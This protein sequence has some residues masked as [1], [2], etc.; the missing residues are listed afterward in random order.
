MKRRSSLAACAI[1]L[2]LSGMSAGC[3]TNNLL[4]WT[5]GEKSV[6]HRPPENDAPYVIPGATVLAFPFVIVWDIVT[7]P[8]QI[9]WGIHPYGG[10]M[11]PDET[12][13]GPDQ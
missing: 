2:A 4:R 7:F 11:D 6:Y 5:R 13:A 1:V 12:E 10:T 3:A 9:I 8:F